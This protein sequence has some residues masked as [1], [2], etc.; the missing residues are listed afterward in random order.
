MYNNPNL[1]LLLEGRPLRS[2]FHQEKRP[3]L[4][5]DSFVNDSLNY[6]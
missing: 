2:D 5:G 4:T 3:A 6:C 1:G